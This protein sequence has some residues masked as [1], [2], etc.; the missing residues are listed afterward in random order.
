MR[1]AVS[2]G[3]RSYADPDALALHNSAEI[4]DAVEGGHTV[5]NGVLCIRVGFVKW[6]GPGI[7]VNV[8]PTGRFPSLV[9]FVQR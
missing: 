8:G 9:G 3:V 4:S 2:G 5:Q 6:F 1:C 7:G